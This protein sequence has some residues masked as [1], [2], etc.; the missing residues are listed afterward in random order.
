[1]NK[2]HV[3]VSLIVCVAL[4]GG[5]GCGESGS[6]ASTPAAGGPTFGS[7]GSGV[8][9]SSSTPTTPATS[10]GGSGGVPI[11]I[12]APSILTVET[13]P[14]SN[15]STSD[16]LMWGSVTAQNVST[17]ERWF[18]F[19]VDPNNL[20]G[21]L[22]PTSEGGIISRPIAGLLEG[23]W[24]WYQQVATSVETGEVRG[25]AIPFFVPVTS[26]PTPDDNEQVRILLRNIGEDLSASQSA[27][28]TAENTLDS[29]WAIEFLEDPETGLVRNSSGDALITG[30]R[31]AQAGETLMNRPIPEGQA[32]D[33]YYRLQELKSAVRELVVWRQYFYVYTLEYAANERSDRAGRSSSGGLG[34]KE[35]AE[36]RPAMKRALDILGVQ[37]LTA[38]QQHLDD[39]LRLARNAA[40]RC[41]QSRMNDMKRTSAKTLAEVD[42]AASDFFL[43]LFLSKRMAPAVDQAG[44]FTERINALEAMV[45]DFLQ[46]L[47]DYETEVDQR[48]LTYLRGLERRLARYP[49]PPP[50]AMATK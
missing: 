16:T 8:S 17:F 43:F 30:V 33:V 10:S 7:S 31:A 6:S 15:V 41:K 40:E 4:V 24:Y 35:T 22:M 21:K 36:N 50:V 47:R 29:A 49:Q 42:E 18:E 34:K 9:T 2:M 11:L 26:P 27:R 23:N 28:A 46:E 45:Q 1:M 39:T 44:M 37:E 25:H 32:W 12:P 5:T 38:S 14:P 20:G 19:G 13:L 3:L 48:V